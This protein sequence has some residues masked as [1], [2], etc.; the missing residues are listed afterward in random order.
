MEPVTDVMNYLK[1]R[2]SYGLTGNY[3]IGNYRY[4]AELALTTMS[5]VVL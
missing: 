2:A 1:I 4:I 3:N 5:W